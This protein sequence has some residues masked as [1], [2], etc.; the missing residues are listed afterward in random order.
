MAIISISSLP[1][2]IGGF[3]PWLVLLVML[4]MAIVPRTRRCGGGMLLGFAIVLGLALL[5]V[6]GLCVAYLAGAGSG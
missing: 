5:V 6:G 4:V 3:L 2:E 1:A